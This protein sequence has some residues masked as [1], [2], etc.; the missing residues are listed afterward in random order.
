MTNN[1]IC[2]INGLY[3]IPLLYLMID[4]SLPL[5]LQHRQA[6]TLGLVILGGFK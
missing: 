5:L 3:T 2:Q 4:F 6:V 1:D